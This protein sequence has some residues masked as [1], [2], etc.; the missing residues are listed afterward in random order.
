M[1]SDMS[2][3]TKV[4]SVL[5]PVQVPA[6]KWK[7]VAIDMVGPL[8]EDGNCHIVV[9]DYFSKWPECKV[10]K[11]KEAVMVAIFL[12]ELVQHY[13]MPDIWISDSNYDRIKPQ[14]GGMPSHDSTKTSTS[15]WYG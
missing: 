3:L 8:P 6:V 7:Q 5:N 11:N 4:G 14:D 2:K 13:G 15:Q 12:V 9:Q 1:H 10:V